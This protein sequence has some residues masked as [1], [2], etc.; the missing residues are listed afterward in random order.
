MQKADLVL[1]GP[2]VTPSGAFA[3]IEPGVVSRAG[4]VEYLAHAAYL[5]RLPVDT[6]ESKFHFCSSAK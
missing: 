2:I 1:Q 4:D 6:D 3:S 5:E